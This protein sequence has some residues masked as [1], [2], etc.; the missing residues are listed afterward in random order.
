MP[1][2]PAS[3]PEPPASIRE[4]AER[5]AQARQSR[6]FAAADQLRAQI[7]DGGWTVTDGPGG[8]ELA[9]AAMASAEP[10]YQVWPDPAAV[11]S[12]P[13]GGGLRGVVPPG[14]HHPRPAT[15]ALL[16]E[17]WPDDLRACVAALLAHAPAGVVISA[18]D[19]G[20]RDGA[21]D[22]LHELSVANP[23][24]IEEWHVATSR[25]WGV[26]RNAL[27]RADPAR[28][29]VIM[30]TSTILT[31]DAISPLLAEIAA[32]GIAAA[33]W[34]GVD[35]DPDLR[36]FHDAGPGPVAALLGYL[37]AVRA[38]AARAAGGLPA[39]ARFYRNAD[40]E[41]SL[42]LRPIG[43]LVVPAGDLPARQ[44]RHRGYYDSDP[45]FRDKESERNYRRVLDL[46]RADSS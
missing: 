35:S 26:S 4:L 6:D 44:S 24:R 20:N 30:E 12:A 17:G 16:V 45:A 22:V 7:G 34:R 41:F 39:R 9:P 37:L 38:D 2:P 18:L 33:G 11:P 40:L 36:G 15:V 1:E 32:D 8:Y 31:G 5:R 46:L 14:Q 25:G 29:H 23:G 28:V 42:R 21:G 13:G 43:R 10:A 27:L 19:V 3:A